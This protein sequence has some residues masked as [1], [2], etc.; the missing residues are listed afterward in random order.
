MSAIPTPVRSVR[1]LVPGLC[2]LALSASALA[3][4]VAAGLATPARAITTV[5]TDAGASWTV[6]D[7]RRPGLDTGSIRN[8]SNSRL[9]AFGSLFVK[10]A[11]TDEPMNGQML[12]GFGLTQTGP[13]R[14]TSTAAVRLGA[15]TVTRTLDIDPVT[16]VATFFDTFTNTGTAA[17]QLEGAFGGALGYGLPGSSTAGTV[18]ASA[19]GDAALDPSDSW[20]VATTPGTNR[21][22]GI[23]TGTGADRLGNQQRDPFTSS[24]E[25]TTSGSNYPALVHALDLEPGSTRSLMHH[26]VVGARGDSTAIVDTTRAL[27]AAPDLSGL[28]VDQICTLENWD[29]TGITGF[30]PAQC[31]GADPLK[32]PAAPQVPAVT[33]SVT[34]DVTDKTVT[35]LSRDLAAGE[36]TAVEITQAYLDRIKAYDQTQL[37]L[38]SFIHVS[39]EALVEAAAADRA[40]AGGD[41]RP[42]LGVPIAIKDLY[43]VEGQ[44]NTGGVAS[45]KTWE[46]ESDAF[47]IA[48][49]R[50]AGMVFLGKTNL[51]EFA[52]SGS[53]SESGFMQSWNG[54]YPSKTSFGSS[55]GSATAV[56][57][58]LAPISMGTQTGVSLYAPATGASLTSFRGTDG[59]TSAEGVMP[60]T[61]AQ[62]YAGPIGQSVSDV[63]LVLDATATR[64]TGNNPD[65]ILTSRVDNDQ[66]PASFSS[67]LDEQALRGKKVGYLPA[68]FVS[69]A[70]ADDTTG[71]DTLADA[72][73]ALASAGAELVE[74]GS[75]AP[76]QP[77]A[78]GPISGNSGAHGWWEYINSEPTFPLRSP[79]AVW[80]NAANLPYN[81]SGTSVDSRTAY[82]VA[83]VSN[84]LA[85]RDAWK[86]AVGE[87]METND[88][89]VVAYPGF[90]SEM[91]NNDASSSVLSSDRAS[92][93]TTSN[94]GLPTA[95]VPV[96]TT[97][98]G[99]SN[100][101][102]LVG[103]A[104]DDADV[105][106]MG[107]ALEQAA[108]AR[109][110]ST[111]APALADS[112][113]AES[114]TS[115]S[116]GATAIT[117]GTTT[118]ATVTVASTRTVA[119]RVS[120]EVG[121]RTVSAALIGGRATVVL[122]SPAT[123]GEFLVTARFAGTATVAASVA[124][125][126]LKVDAAPVTRP[127]A[128][129]TPAAKAAA[130]LKVSVKGTRK[131]TKRLVIRVTADR[132]VTGVVR[133]RTGSG[134]TVRRAT[135]KRGT[136][137]VTVPRTFARAKK[138]TVRYTGSATVKAAQRTVRGTAR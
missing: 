88:V 97:G 26:V 54:L 123:P 104:W 25:P 90:L 23:V 2:A 12:R 126:V 21:A 99:Y 133:V 79:A 35:D 86:V 106:G 78:P 41:T 93:V 22:T 120:V 29:L 44:P 128:P 65:D 18:A 14:Y 34:Y 40:R 129:T 60:L 80:K 33:T 76:S 71:A 27:A 137:T 20:A 134:A 45:L 70:I 102:Q 47:Q 56:A 51:S 67:A 30:E 15:V 108:Q 57:A 117:Q 7:G 58:A 1:R 83:S 64:T 110:H 3:V 116:L 94:V 85:R 46:P 53:F 114:L 136:V 95:I 92:S 17:V 16:D 74:M 125:G 124:T 39:D 73:A 91:G 38:K 89:D 75:P 131:A 132:S 9:E 8:V 112:G 121:G 122:P 101:L 61:W 68:S 48:R 19:S 6:N 63:A 43:D 69:N 77:A 84:L 4:P 130:T 32:L 72:R 103:A 66:R 115:L 13:Y 24:Y 28:S 138:F 36:V 59:L 111:V 109:V 113:P 49:L 119:G 87:W 118:K 100:S 37:G 42:L 55:G 11:G 105:L 5:V 10:V 107:Y 62:D 82:D 81:V 135:L 50:E 98:A 127:T 31:A 52:N 96:G